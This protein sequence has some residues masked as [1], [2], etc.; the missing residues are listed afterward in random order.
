MNECGGERSST[1]A[2]A[3]TGSPSV[4]ASPIGDPLDAPKEGALSGRVK[5]GLRFS[6]INTVFSRLATFAV[7]VVLARLLVPEQFG[8][9]TTALVVQTMLLTF[10]DFGTATALVRHEGDVRRLLP[11]VWTI[12]V[13][14]ACAVYGVC[15]LT[16][17]L[18]ASGLGVPQ[19]AGL[20][21]VLSLNVLLDGF[22]AVP[23]ALLT[24]NLRQ[25]RR[26][27]ADASGLVANLV[28]TAT[29]AAAGFG[30]WALVI[31][32]VGGTV[33]VTVLLLVVAKQV[34]RFGISWKHTEEV[35]RYGGAVVVSSILM[36][37]LQYAPQTITG[38]MLGATAL[39]FFYLASNV[40]S[41]PASVVTTT[42]ERVGLATF[43]RARDAGV[44]LDKAASAVI[45]MVAMAVLPAGA[46]LALL[47]PE[48]VDVVYGDKW[49]P[50]APV[51]AGL[52]VA[53]I[54]R[55]LADL[56][57]NLMI[58]AGS[59]LSSVLVQV[60]WLFALVP[61]A[62]TATAR[63]GLVGMG[64]AVAVVACLVAL[65]VH[66]WGLRR[67]G[68]RV[69]VLLRGLALPVLF[70][71]I[72][73]ATLLFLS[74]IVHGTLPYLLVGG[75][76]TAIVVTVGWLARGDRLTLALDTPVKA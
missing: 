47:A 58:T 8:L 33:V 38:R 68:V 56:V 17:S 9:Y 37:L 64:W 30:A 21:R 75:A 48:V 35:I 29:L 49:A 4:V 53:A 24:R 76:V 32:H 57:F 59:A 23:G 28:L 74:L 55:V 45:G 20:I 50:A 36:V 44:D 54:A 5:L 25:A 14:G 34:P 15:L 66:V 16:S 39:G 61:A 3:L 19:A 73:V 40:S 63:W 43:S 65:P 52:A 27:I 6:L 69:H 22:A 41:W 1:V 7:G 62:I 11:T 10:N 51:L 31:G 71:V 70:T 72:T 2:L 18:L 12:S 42:I 46:A 26:L 13:G 67:A 60:I